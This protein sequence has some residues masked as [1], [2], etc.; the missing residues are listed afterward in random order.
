MLSVDS[1]SE[2]DFWGKLGGMIRMIVE[3]YREI[4][5]LSVR[6]KTRVK[7]IEGEGKEIAEEVKV[8]EAEEV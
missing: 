2:M 4:F 3:E 7:V 1:S 8:F 6:P 5:S